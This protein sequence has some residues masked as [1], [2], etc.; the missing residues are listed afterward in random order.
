[1]ANPIYSRRGSMNLLASRPTG[2]VFHARKPIIHNLEQ[3]GKHIIY[4]NIMTLFYLFLV[5]EASRRI[6]IRA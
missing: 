6:F 4:I 2:A 1:M 3:V 5:I